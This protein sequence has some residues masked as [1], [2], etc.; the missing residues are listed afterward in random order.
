MPEAVMVI[1]KNVFRDEEYSEP[2]RVLEAHGIGVTT[3]ST[4]A[5]ECI[6][7]LGLAARADV[8]LHDI[9]ADAWDAVVF[10]GGA[11]ASIFFDDPDAHRLARLTLERGGVVGAICIA[12]STL[13]HAEL[14]EGVTAT[15][16]SSQEADLREH[17]AVW[18]EGPVVRHGRIVTADGPAAAI[19][20]GEAIADL[21]GG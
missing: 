10:I 16:F 13:A 4:A 19:A 1:A 15:A 8:A 7:K 3:A 18:S 5:G 12:P 9:S 17:G 6:G 14:L 11:G 21:L 20:F 2:K